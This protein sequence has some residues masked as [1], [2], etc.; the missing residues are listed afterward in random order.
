MCESYGE[1]IGRAMLDGIDYDMRSSG[2]FIVKLIRLSGEWKIVSLECVYD[3][4]NLVPIQAQK[5][6][7]GGPLEIDFPRE[8]Y[9]GLAYVLQKLGGYRIDENLPG[10]DR[11]EKA[12]ELLEKSR[13][14]V[15]TG[16][17]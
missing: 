14:W 4:D 15:K 5:S 1:I 17:M 3:K 9:K 16:W 11:P 10:F 13:N 8:S 7:P 6:L 2:T 12:L